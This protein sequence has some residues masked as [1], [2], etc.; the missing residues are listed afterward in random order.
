MVGSSNVLAH[1][2]ANSARPAPEM[3]MYVIVILLP[4]QTDPISQKD[5]YFI[6]LHVS[7]ELQ[8]LL[9]HP[10]FIAI[11]SWGLFYHAN[12][13]CC[14]GIKSSVE[15]KELFNRVPTPELQVVCW[16]SSMHGRQGSKG[17]TYELIPCYLCHNLEQLRRRRD[18]LTP[19]VTKQG[20]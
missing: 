14:I 1:V 18:S 20:C 5:L 6:T 15:T 19:E 3:P 9:E 4:R 17:L 13:I 8:E 12:H 7:N 11:H 16:N 2:W 10:L